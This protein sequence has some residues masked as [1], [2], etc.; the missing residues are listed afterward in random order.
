M[1]N[2]KSQI[3]KYS[4]STEFLRLMWNRIIHGGFK[5]GTSLD[6]AER[7]V[8]FSIIALDRLYK[9]FTSGNLEYLVDVANL[10]MLEYQWPS[11]PK[12]HFK[13]DDSNEGAYDD[14]R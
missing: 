11:H 8:N 12:A 13:A 7:G 14:N 3:I 1:D 9:Y 10:C 2:Q 5:R 4:W 6:N